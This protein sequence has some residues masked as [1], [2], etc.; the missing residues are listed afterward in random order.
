MFE[1]FMNDTI[2]IQK[3]NGDKVE[4]LKASVQSPLIHLDNPAVV[5]EIGDLIERRMS[6]GA[7]ETYEVLDP[8]FYEA[9]H[10]FPPHYKLRVRKLG[11][12][13][14]KAR[15]QS[16]TYNISGH[17][18]RVNHDSVDNSTNTVT[19]GNDLQDY[20]DALRQVIST[21]GDAQRK[22]A[23]EIVD[24]VAAN[25]ASQKP[26]KT[27]VSALLSALPHLASISTI[28]SSILAAL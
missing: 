5:V 21:L 2:A 24:A 3:Q 16:I 1:E 19:I 9:F 6:N 14:A 4:G 11:V 10:G 17:N 27:V 13:E 26:S 12:P 22:D 8:D 7:I 23:S 25:L 18:A 20:V 15:V 28:T